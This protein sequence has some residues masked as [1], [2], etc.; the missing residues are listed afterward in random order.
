MWIYTSDLLFPGMVWSCKLCCY[1][2]SWHPCLITFLMQKLEHW[3]RKSR[4]W[5][6]QWDIWMSSDLIWWR[7]NHKPPLCAELSFLAKEASLLLLGQSSLFG[8]STMSS[9]RCF[10]YKGL[11]DPHF[12][13]YNLVLPPRFISPCRAH[14][15][16]VMWAQETVADNLSCS[17]QKGMIHRR[18]SRSCHRDSSLGPLQPRACLLAGAMIAPASS[19][20]P[21][22]SGLLLAGRF[23]KGTMLAS[24]SGTYG[25]WPFASVPYGRT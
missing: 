18:V 25:L 15:I 14:C 23:E 1:K 5:E 11:R 9:P 24:E 16:L 19:H 20:L 13:F 4:T 12:Y 2:S 10:T 22:H 3:L 21:N 6:L 8:P 17:S 7:W